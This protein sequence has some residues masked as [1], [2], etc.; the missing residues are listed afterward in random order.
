MGGGRWDKAEYNL[1]RSTR[2]MSATVKGIRAEDEDFAYSVRAKQDRS[3]GVHPNLDP[4]RINKK[5]FGKLESRDSAE[6][7]SSNPVFVGFDV[8]GSNFERAVE[9]QKRLPNLMTMLGKYLPDP[10]VLVAA[11]DDYQYVGNR[12][13]QVSDYESDIRVDDHIRNV[14]LVGQGGGNMGESYDLL[15]YC[16]A[17]KT[18]LDSME[19]RNRKGYLFLYA[20]E[21]FFKKVRKE[22]VLAIFG[23]K[24]QADIPIADII[25]ETKKLYNVFIIW[26]LGGYIEARNQYE[27]LFGEKSVL[28]L[29]DPNLICE[30]IG[31]VVGINEEMIADTS[32]LTNDLTEAGADSTSVASILTSIKRKFRL[33]ETGATA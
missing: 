5:P 25:E 12:T 20:D 21:P 11:N 22:E 24:L 32:S 3:I 10:Q 9:A 16:A 30:L 17:R 33:P 8:T 23:D 27:K 2:L 6:H 14:I 13:I 29:Q 28:T 7:P 31:S 18:I 15:L 19:K 26:P 4:L 1:L